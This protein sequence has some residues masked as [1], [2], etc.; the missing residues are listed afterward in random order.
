M[1]TQRITFDNILVTGSALRD[2]LHTGLA[3]L[4]RRDVK[5][6]A[7]AERTKA[8]DSIDLDEATRRQFPESNRWDYLISVPS[9][10]YVVALE[11]HSAKDSEVSG[12]IRKKQ[13]AVAF[14]YDHLPPRHRVAR[15]LWVS[16][17]PVTFTRMD[18]AVRLLDQ[19]GIKF[20]GH[21]LRSL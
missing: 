5:L 14:L 8:G 17:G 9:K 21:M 2:Y 15:W 11:P 12:V 19:H 7:V 1:A 13:P 3:A 4:K 20:V 6:I 16:H 18:K 10:S